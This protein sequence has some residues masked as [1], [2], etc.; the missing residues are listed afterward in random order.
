MA[1]IKKKI[2]TALQ[3]GVSANKENRIFMLKGDASNNKSFL[4][5]KGGIKMIT[6]TLDEAKE[7]GFFARTT[8]ST[9]L[10]DRWLME[11]L[12]YCTAK[13]IPFI[14]FEVRHKYA[15]MSFYTMTMDDLKNGYQHEMM[16]TARLHILK[17]LKETN[18]GEFARVSDYDGYAENIRVDCID[19]VVRMIYYHTMPKRIGGG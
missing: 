16:P 7:N 12:D 19:K 3:A 1:K 15:T 17:A 4:T 13:R 2:L 18:G 6:T 14:D 11:F 10:H 5:L 8:K 9:P